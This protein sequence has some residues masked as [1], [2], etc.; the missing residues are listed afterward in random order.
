MGTLR[1]IIRIGHGDTVHPTG[2][3]AGEAAG[4]TDPTIPGDIRPITEDIMV[5]TT[6]VIMGMEDIPITAI[7]V[8]EDIMVGII[9]LPGIGIRTIT[10][11]VKEEQPEQMYIVEPMEQEEPQQ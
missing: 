3:G 7:M 6:E 9:T 8:T 5:G 10:N 11:T 4:I 1:G 2:V